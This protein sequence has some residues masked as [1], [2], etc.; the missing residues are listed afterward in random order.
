MAE[1]SSNPYDFSA[2]SAALLVQLVQEIEQTPAQYWA[3]L[4][5]TIRQFRQGLGATPSA[6]EQAWD[7]ALQAAA[8][9]SSERQATLSQLLNT[10]MEDE[11]DREQAETWQFLNQALDSD[12]LSNRPFFP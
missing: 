1:P 10:W 7:E 12:R 6:S 11:D 3:G 8:A 9:P 5:Q 4:L 2:A